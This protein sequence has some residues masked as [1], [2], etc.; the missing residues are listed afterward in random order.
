MF[1]NRK[2]NF[3]YYRVCDHNYQFLYRLVY[4]SKSWFN[5]KNLRLLDRKKRLI[6][7][8]IFQKEL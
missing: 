2:R 7:L 8:L 1:R 4:I 5:I 6:F 3:F